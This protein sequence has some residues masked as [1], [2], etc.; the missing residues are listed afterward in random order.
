MSDTDLIQFR[1]ILRKEFEVMSIEVVTCI[2]THA[3][4]FSEGS[5]SFIVC[6]CSLRIF[7]VGFCISFG[8]Q[9]YPVSSRICR[10]MDHIC[11]R[12]YKNRYTDPCLFKDF[13][14]LP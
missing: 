7:Q 1:D 6:N 14:H 10:T 4:T 9:F 5:S 13:D 3:Q 12:V 11:Y 2:H 8:I